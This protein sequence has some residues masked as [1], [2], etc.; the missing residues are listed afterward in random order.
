M[1]EITNK[2]LFDLGRLAATAGALAA[3]EKTRQNAV[4][5]LARHVTGDWGEL[6]VEDRAE[7]H[8]SSQQGFRLLSSYRTPAGDKMW[9]ITEADHSATTLQLPE[10]Y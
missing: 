3:L 8:L 5:F 9:V 4:E 2:P 1:Q 6:P 10:E 7:N